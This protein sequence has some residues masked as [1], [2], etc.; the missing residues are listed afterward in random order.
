[1]VAL[2]GSQERDEQQQPSAILDQLKT[3]IGGW[4]LLT[5]QNN[6]YSAQNS[7]FKHW[8]QSLLDEVCEVLSGR[9]KGM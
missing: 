8:P 5:N 1:M 3:G 7:K 2:L 4:R 9:A 6:N